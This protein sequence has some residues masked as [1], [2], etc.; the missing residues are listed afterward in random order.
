MSVYEERFYLSKDGLRLFYRD[1]PNPSSKTPVLCIPGLTRNARDFDF[2]AGHIARTRRVLA[3]DLRGRGRSAYDPDNRN[4]SVPVETGDV[5]QLLSTIGAPQVVVL[6]T[7]RGGVIAMTMASFVPSTVKAAILNDMGA[8]LDAKGLERIY[9]VMRTPPNYASWDDAAVAL[10][11]NNER[12]ISNV[13]DERWLQFARALYREDN[14]RIVGDYDPQFPQAILEGRGTNPRT[15]AGAADLWK[16]F[17]ALRDKPTLVLRGENSE[18]LSAETV[19]EMKAKK[20][21]LVAVS[22][23]DRGHVPFL[24]EPEAVAA[25]DTFL[26]AID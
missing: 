2:I 13:G 23:K 26:S 8:L 12:Q 21:D 1:Y 6:G 24:D 5:F 11:R 19:A 3:T 20:T 16:W 17:G 4:Y 25:I 7:S 10:K 9:A 22:V 15:D 14:G 18:L